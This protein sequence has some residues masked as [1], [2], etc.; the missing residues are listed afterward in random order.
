[1]SGTS[2]LVSVII[3]AFNAE[4]HIAQTLESVLAQSYRR[5]EVIVVD[6]GSE[7]RTSDIARDFVRKD[8]RLKVL[9][10]PNRG[11]AA[12]R[13]RAIA[14]SNGEFIAPIDADDQWCPSKVQ[15]Q[16][17]TLSNSPSIV[18]LVYVWS[19]RIDESNAVVGQCSGRHIEGSVYLPLLIGNFIG[20]SSAPLIRRECF[21]AVGGY[22]EAFWR[23]NAQGCE[24]WDIYLRIAERYRF[25]VIPDCLVRYRQTAGGMSADTEKMKASHRLLLD[26]VRK[27]HPSISSFV[28]RWS[29]SA[30]MLYVATTCTRGADAGKGLACLLKAV[31]LD[32]PMVLNMHL[33]R[34]FFRNVARILGISA[35][36]KTEARFRGAETASRDQAE[37]AF[38]APW[39]RIRDRKQV[40][41]V[42]LQRV[43]GLE[44]TATP[45]S[46]RL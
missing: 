41:L 30:Y 36:R 33:H 24:D 22:D 43:L 39:T 20:N 1:M 29:T 21:E 2:G 6:D 28:Y 14:E 4:R 34:L 18:G 44:V 8:S 40:R 37:D 32:P 9:Y 11:V 17:E 35:G 42:K 12:A 16:V 7:D 19:Q 5:L 23:C 15:R 3:P 45:D 38:G 46:R 25:S 26:S 10:Q 31:F 27:R 13:N